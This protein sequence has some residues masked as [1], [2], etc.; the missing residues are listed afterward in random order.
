MPIGRWFSTI[1]AALLAALAA[2][3]LPGAAFAQA[4][5]A[6]AYT[7]D[8]VDVDATGADPIKARDQGIRD[9]RRKALQM[10]VDRMVPPEDRARLP[11]VN[12]AQLEGMVRGVEFVRERSAPGRYIGTLNVIFAPDQVKS[13]IG[14]SGAKTVETVQKPALVVPLWKG[15]DGI[16]P[17]DDRNPWRDAWQQLDGANSTVP[18]TVMRGDPTDQGAM[19]PEEAYVGDISALSRL[20]ARYRMP[21]IIV[22]TVEGDKASG[23]LT[24]SGLRYDTQTGLRTDIAKTSLPDAAQLA[25]AAKKVHAK[26][27]E[28]WRGIATVRRDSQDSL[29]VVVPIRALSD[30]VQVRQRLGSV[31]AVKN[32]A[33]KQLESDRAELRLDY[34]GSPEELQRILA[35]AGLQL[36]KDAD[37]WRLQPR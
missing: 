25:D 33:V 2:G 13:W 8:G 31:P 26:V 19:S 34:F 5:A 29:D 27:E 30:W 15:R 7:V 12:D 32:V 21:T 1:V 36:D 14:G 18:V 35:Q 6:N 37:Q 11:Q 22:V 23:P 3:I 4:P 24:V 16:Q 9:A 20:N 28:D 10:L 17:L